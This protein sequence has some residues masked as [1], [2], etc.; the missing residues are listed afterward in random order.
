MYIYRSFYQNSIILF[1]LFLL[2]HFHVSSMQSPF[3]LTVLNQKQVVHVSDNIHTNSLMPTLPDYP[4]VSRIRNESPGLP[5]GWSILP[6]KYDFEPF[7]F[8]WNM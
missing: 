4:G 5:Y 7:F 1:T 3:I 8:V 2:Q 6:D